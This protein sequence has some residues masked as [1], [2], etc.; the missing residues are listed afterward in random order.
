MFC[1]NVVDVQETVKIGIAPQLKKKK[2]H[3]RF[4]VLLSSPR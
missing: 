4:E 2:A 3:K 1:Q